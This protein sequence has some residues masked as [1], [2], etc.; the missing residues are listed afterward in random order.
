[1]KKQIFSCLLLLSVLLPISAFAQ[2][3]VD[4]NPNTSTCVSLQNSLRY[5]SRDVS[6]NGEVSTLQDFLQ[7]KGYLNSEPT[8]YFGLLTVAAVKSFQSASGMGGDGYVGPPTRAKIK[9]VSCGGVDT[10]PTQSSIPGCF[11]GALYSSITGQPCSVSTNFSPGCRSSSGFS[12]TT[13][14]P[15]GQTDYAEPK[16]E[17]KSNNGEKVVNISKGEFVYIHWTSQNTFSCTAVGSSWDRLGLSETLATSGYIG[18]RPEVSGEY[19]ISCKGITKTV[20]DSM[21]V[22]VNSVPSCPTSGFDPKTGMPCGCTTNSGWS[23]TTGVS[24][25]NTGTSTL[26]ITTPSVL[27]NAKVGQRYSVTLNTSGVDPNNGYNWI[28][29]N[30]SAAFPVTGLSFGPSY[31]NSNYIT[32]VPAE[33]YLDGVKQTTPYTF[34]F[35]VAVNS[36]PQTATKLF[37]LTVV[38]ASTNFPPGCSSTS[39]WSTTTGE[40]CSDKLLAPSVDL[41]VNGSNGPITTPS[42]DTPVTLSWTSALSGGNYTC[43]AKQGFSN[44][45]G[46]LEANGYRTVI[47]SVVTS[48]IVLATGSPASGIEYSITCTNSNSGAENSDFVH[49]S[50]ANY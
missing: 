11:R 41:K 13:G 21:K 43:S 15:C 14:L 46:N 12:F 50:F 8:G 25:G 27:P 33:I 3:D 37:S 1:M 35:N 7:S 38:P 26:S 29:N 20:S 23:T 17:V 22:N 40:S 32:G 19:T 44:W 49:V 34:S 45:G 2:A 6:T 42:A 48:E 36:G 18:V 47:P 28:A 9:A 5:Q 4:P 24:C 16:V 31:G 10:T 30:G 39:G